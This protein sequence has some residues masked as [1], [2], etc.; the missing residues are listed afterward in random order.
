MLNL[1]QMKTTLKTSTVPHSEHSRG[2]ILWAIDPSEPETQPERSLTHELL[3]WAKIAKIKIQATYALPKPVSEVGYPLDVPDLAHYMDAAKQT[4]ERYLKEIGAGE[5]MPVHLLPVESTSRKEFVSQIDEQADQLRSPCIAVSSHGRSGLPRFVLGSFSENL[6]RHSSHPI[7]F[8]THD[9][10]AY[11][12]DD[13]VTRVLFPTD[14]S[15]LSRQA[16]HHFLIAT[17]GLP[18]ELVL[19]H[20]VFLPEAV[21]ESEFGAAVDIPDDYIPNQLSWAKTEANR[22]VRVALAHGTRCRFVVHE[23]GIGPDTGKTI[24]SLADR[25]G[26]ALI[27]MA[28]VEGPIRSLLFG[29]VAD[30]VFRANRYPVWMY[31]PTSL[32]KLPHSNLVPV[33]FS[34]TMDTMSIAKPAV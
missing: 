33:E 25:E 32:V 24:L 7:L 10:P 8:L 4:A 1:S 34:E 17:R 26:I 23:D 18:I 28:A 30:H 6:L 3:R 12:H 19:F 5:T 9:M 2:T 29:S 22:W 11:K 31:G 15:D 27:V 13:A 14:F 16:Y 21:L 20:S